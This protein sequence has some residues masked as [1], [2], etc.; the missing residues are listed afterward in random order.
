MG[1]I[2]HSEIW[3]YVKPNSA[4]V[5]RPWRPHMVALTHRICHPQTMPPLTGL[6]RESS[7]QRVSSVNFR[8]GGACSRSRSLVPNNYQLGMMIT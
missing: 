6:K 3:S 4:I 8:H 7:G 2:S 1:I 5:W